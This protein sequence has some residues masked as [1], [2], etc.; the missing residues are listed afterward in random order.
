LDASRHFRIDFDY[1]DLDV[2]FLAVSG[3]IVAFVEMELREAADAAIDGLNGARSNTAAR[4]MPWFAFTTRLA[5][6]SKRTSTTAIS[7]SLC[8]R[9]VHERLEL[10]W[11]FANRQELIKPGVN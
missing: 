6:S 2:F 10:L 7:K 11:I 4:M 9:R 5:R 1:R 8:S 3:K